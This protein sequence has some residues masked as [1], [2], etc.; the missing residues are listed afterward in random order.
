MGGTDKEI[1]LADETLETLGGA[2]V[3]SADNR[4]LVDNTFEG[5][6]RRFETAL[7]QILMGRMFPHSAELGAPVH[8]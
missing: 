1:R 4:I 5:R 8:G 6:Q 3:R 2:V 7:L